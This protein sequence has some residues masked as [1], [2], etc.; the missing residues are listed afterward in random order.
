MAIACSHAASEAVEHGGALPGSAGC[1]AHA[2]DRGAG[3]GGTSGRWDGL[4]EA[5]PSWVEVACLGRVDVTCLMELAIR[6]ARRILFVPGDCLHCPHAAGIA[7][8]A[9]TLRDA[10]VLLAAFGADLALEIP[11]A[12]EAGEAEVSGSQAVAGE[13]GAK[14]LTLRDLAE[15]P[16]TPP[17]AARLASDV[18]ARREGF[19]D[20]CYLQSVADEGG[21]EASGGT[22]V[23]GESVEEPEASAAPDEQGQDAPRPPRVGRDGVL[24]Q[25]V[26]PR[27]TRLFNC[28]KALGTPTVER[29][30]LATGLWG[31][32]SIDASRCDGCRMCAVFCPTGALRR[33]PEGAPTFGVT[34]QPTFCVQCGTC[35]ATCPR[36]AITL[37]PA[38][39]PRTF[40]RGTK[41][42]LAMDEPDW[43]PNRPDSIYRKVFGMLGTDNNLAV[44]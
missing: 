21:D 17:E 9:D 22:D 1:D 18:V 30:P 23:D 38:V 15:L 2:G 3:A 6:G 27:R 7:V 13:A 29:E 19:E 25:F 44:Y 12:N 14:P 43:K 42:T 33:T 26:P 41:T 8:L 10:G 34:H 20:G 37:S 5:R 39:A 40:L 11:A 16:A 36:R 32:V 28:L 35:E 24:P 4:P 31:T